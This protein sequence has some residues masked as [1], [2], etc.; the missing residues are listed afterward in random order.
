MDGNLPQS[1]TE[2]LVSETYLSIHKLVL[3]DSFS[4]E[5]VDTLTNE[6]KENT[7]TVCGIIQNE[8]QEKENSFIF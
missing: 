8:T 4:F 2:V 3:G 6:L 5:Y 7:F 1:N